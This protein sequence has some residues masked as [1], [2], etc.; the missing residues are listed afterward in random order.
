M[1]IQKKGILWLVFILLFGLTLLGSGYWYQ[2]NV[3]NGYPDTPKFADKINR[4]DET[5]NQITVLIFHKP[6]CSDCQRIRPTV[7]QVIKSKRNVNYIVINVS[8]Q[9]AKTFIAQYGITEVPTIIRLKGTRVIDSTTSTQTK[10]VR[11]V[12]TGD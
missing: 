8:K 4:L 9:D 11:Q 6:G 7:K 12:M 1:K 5:S 2:N 10:S 3:L